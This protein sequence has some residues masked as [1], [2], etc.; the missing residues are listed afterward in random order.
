MDRPRL[1][2]IAL[3]VVSAIAF[4]SGGL[5]AKPVYAAGVDWL[6]LMAWRFAIA[7]GLAW[8]VLLAR[9][10]ARR[11]LRHCPAHGPRHDRLARA[12]RR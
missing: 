3:V 4:G 5:F 2:G 9:P 12:V 1:T 8:L 10:G 6:T 11:A 7:G